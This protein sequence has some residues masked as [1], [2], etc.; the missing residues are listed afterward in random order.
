MLSTIRR[1]HTRQAINS[2]YSK[3]VSKRF[4]STTQIR[5][6]NAAEVEKLNIL[7]KQKMA[8]IEEAEKKRKFEDSVCITN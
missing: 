3:S 1:T 5:Y 7:L 6:N 8:E 4:I 2:C